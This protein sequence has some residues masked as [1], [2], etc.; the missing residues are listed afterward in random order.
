MPACED[1]RAQ[2]DPL[3]APYIGTVVTVEKGN[4]KIPKSTKSK[5]KKQAVAAKKYKQSVSAIV[6][7]EPSLSH[8]LTASLH[9]SLTPSRSLPH[10]FSPSLQHAQA[11]FQRRFLLS[12]SPYPPGRTPLS[13]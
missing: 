5:S 11:P 8:S 6:I 13:G 7:D 1:R 12:L 4:R 9:H 2:V 3:W 10:S